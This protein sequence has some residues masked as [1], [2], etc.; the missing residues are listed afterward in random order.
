M[1]RSGSCRIRPATRNV[2]APIRSRSPIPIFNVAAK[3]GSIQASLRPNGVLR[4]TPV[5]V[6]ISMEPRRGYPS[7]TVLIA[8]RRL[9]A[10]A[11]SP[12]C[13]MLGNWL[14][15]TI[16]RPCA[17]AASTQAFGVTRS[18]TNTRSAARVL[19]ASV[20][21]AWRTRSASKP[22][23][24]TAVT[25]ITSA[26]HNKVAPPCRRSRQVRNQASCIEVPQQFQFSLLELQEPSPPQRPL[27]LQRRMTPAQFQ[28]R[29]QIRRRV[30]KSFG[31]LWLKIRP[32]AS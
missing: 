20:A 9:R 3:A 19:W 13:A 10:L 29:V 17:C 2:T 8:A 24:L 15:I 4:V 12:T 7:V 14:P 1:P 11:P 25:E 21:S 18:E 31:S 27:P 32:I 30:R 16:R 28:V 6:W 22:T 5:A 26:R 23:A